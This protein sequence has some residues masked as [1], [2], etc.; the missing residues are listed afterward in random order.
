VAARL[1]RQYFILSFFYLSR[2]LLYIE[3]F[4]CKVMR[5]TSNNSSGNEDKDSSK[6]SNRL[7]DNGNEDKDS[8]SR[9]NR[10]ED[11]GNED[12]DS[13]SGSIR[14]EDN[15]HDNSGSGSNRSAND[16][17]AN[18]LVF[19]AFC[20]ENRLMILENLQNGEKC[21]CV[22]LEKLKISQ[23]TLS[24]HMGILCT[25]RIVSSRK[26]GKWTY[27]SI[28]QSGS[29]HALD[30]LEQLTSVSEGSTGETEGC[31]S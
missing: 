24:H 5:M 31:C 19:R 4:L 23:P 9:S 16:H 10:F 8:G 3:S 15:N 22:L 27:Y 1:S 21:A 26:E 30:L 20:D 11:S 12:K 6:G 18:A 7:E 25:S 17:H 29:K 2:T 28:S 13:G 14:L